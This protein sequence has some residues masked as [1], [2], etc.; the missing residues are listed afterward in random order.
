MPSSP[1]FMIVSVTLCLAGGWTTVASEPAPI[2][3]SISPI[4]QVRHS[5]SSF[6]KRK[7]TSTNQELAEA[8]AQNLRQSTM[9]RF[10]VDI[11]T[12][13]GIVYLT[14]EVSD[15]RQKADIIRLVKLVP[16]VQ[17]VVTQLRV[18]TEPL[19]PV[20]AIL[21]PKDLLP[22]PQPRKEAPK[23]PPSPLTG[24]QQ[25]PTPLFRGVHPGDI[26]QGS[27]VPGP[28]P[29]TYNPPRMPPYAWPTYAPYNNYSRVAYPKLY[30]Y[31]AWPYIGPMYPFP[32][33]PLG[34]RSVSLTWEDGYWYY[35]RNATGH[36]W[37]RVR[38][39]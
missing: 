9:E 8:I 10:F 18:R 11:T 38:F 33:V 5:E 34:W 6:E 17:D 4:P 3:D 39:W 29:K 31:N 15:L 16:G 7:D 13:S 37:W 19:Q 24:Q 1:R 23:P 12:Q 26:P 30:P 20:Q 36:D 22:G 27:G 25:D 2:P 35:G 32:K 14:G 21:E 28:D